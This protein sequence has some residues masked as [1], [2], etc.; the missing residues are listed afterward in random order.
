MAKEE[1]EILEE[2]DEDEVPE[3]FELE[4]VEDEED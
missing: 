2:V 1:L 4:E 3:D